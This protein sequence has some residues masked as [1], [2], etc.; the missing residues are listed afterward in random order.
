MDDALTEFRT[1]HAPLAAYL[2]MSGVV[3]SQILYEK[4]RAT[5]VF[6]DVPRDLIIDY[7]NNKALVEPNEFAAKMS[8]L[9]QTT[10]RLM[11][12]GEV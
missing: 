9:I 12:E 1:S 7:N 2:K 8:D 10:K 11:R 5:F 4:K 6:T 3:I